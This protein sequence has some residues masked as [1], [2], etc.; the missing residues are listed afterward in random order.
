RRGQ[1]PT[2]APSAP[3]R[4]RAAASGSTA[5]VIARTTTIRAAPSATTSCTLPASSP[6]IANHGL[7]TVAAAC[8]TYSRPAAGRPGL[9]GVAGRLVPQLEDV[10]ATAQRRV[11]PGARPRGADEVQ[12]GG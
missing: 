11:E 7:P 1:A 9:A 6:P 8:A 3:R 2:G 4:A 12:A 10:H 5:S